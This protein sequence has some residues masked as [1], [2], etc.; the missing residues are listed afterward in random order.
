M[1]GK[2]KYGKLEK[3]F[4]HPGTMTTDKTSEASAPLPGSE[5]L[6]PFT[7]SG[8]N[9]FDLQIANDLFEEYAKDKDPRVL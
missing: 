5:G 9:K 8:A 2:R 1:T 6:K 3:Y 4:P 7:W